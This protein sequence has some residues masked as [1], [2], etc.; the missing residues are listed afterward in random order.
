MQI[1]FH[2]GIT[3]VL[4]RMSGFSPFESN[5]IASSSQYVDDAIREGTIYFD[6]NALYE[7]TA[8][9]HRMLDYRNFAEL[10]NHHVWIPF[11]FIPGN[12]VLPHV[13]IEPEVQKLICKPNSLI[14]QD[15]T[16][17]CVQAFSK[18]FGFH[19]LGVVTH[20]YADTWAHQG[21]AGITHRVNK[22]AEIF[23]SSGATDTDMMNYRKKY[24]TRP[25]YARIKD[26]LT[27]FFVGEANPIGHGTVLSYPDLPFLRWS[28][29]DWN[30]QRVERDNPRDYMD[31]IHH[32]LDFYKELRQAHGL[33]VLKIQD[34]DL[35]ALKDLILNITDEEGDRRLERWKEAVQE[36]R[37]SFGQDVWN[38]HLEGS[39][40]WLK[41]AFDIDL[42]EE[43]YT[44]NV[45]YRAEF[46]KSNWKFIHDAL[47]YHRFIMLHE[48]LPKYQICMA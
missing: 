27:S 46:L 10:A 8:S 17:N 44:L 3:Y 41:E 13:S 36:G 1:D 11:H 28:Y 48:I 39:Q 22:V 47:I 23:D 7:F 12:E 26:W 21:F 29:S 6:N 31:A 14:A 9:A 30:N 33:T 34:H 20:S 37:F 24:F 4:A 16:K 18:S 5:T 19:L 2:L 25:W 15:M 45:P 35:M 38:Y 40:S 32:V 43:F 42:D